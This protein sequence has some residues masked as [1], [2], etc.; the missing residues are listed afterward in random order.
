MLRIMNTLGRILPF[1]IL[2]SVA[3]ACGKAGST[4]FSAPKPPGDASSS[5]SS[6]KAVLS[7]TT[8]TQNTDGT[9][10][11]DATGYRIYYGPNA[12][13]PESMLEVSDPAAVTLTIDHLGTGTYYFSISTLSAT[14]GE[15]PKSNAASKTFSSCE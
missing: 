5:C 6:N 2:T 8:P 10:L 13:N 12:A 15:G 3:S 4:R 11:T 7:W 9:P 1:L 14:G